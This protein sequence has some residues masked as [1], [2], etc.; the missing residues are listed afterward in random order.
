MSAHAKALESRGFV[1]YCRSI[2]TVE[3]ARLSPLRRQDGSWQGQRPYL[4]YMYED[5]L[6]T[7]GPG[8][9]AILLRFATDV[10]YVNMY[11]VARTRLEDVRRPDGV[12]YLELLAFKV[13]K[14]SRGAPPLN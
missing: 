14:E 13:D 2:N 9:S 1:L 10:K 6:C 8:D 4:R 5:Q 7:L 12:E 11:L 3:D